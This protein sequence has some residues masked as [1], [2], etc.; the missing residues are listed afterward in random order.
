METANIDI[1]TLQL[2]NAR[3][4]QTL[5]ALNQVRMSVQ[6]LSH[7]SGI[8]NPLA[9][10]AAYG[11]VYG[12][13]FANAAMTGIG[14]TNGNVGFNPYAAQIL[15]QQALAQQAYATGSLAQAWGTPV[16][17]AYLSQG[18]AHTT[19]AVLGNPYFNQINA[20]TFGSVVDPYWTQRVS[21]TFPFAQWGNSPFVGQMF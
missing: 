9:A 17:P 8:L 13:P 5:E 16:N 7:T 2:L 12:T 4:A 1:R 11:Q 3:F 10:Q 14:H 21:Q 15:A 20:N 18:L 6:G 19:G